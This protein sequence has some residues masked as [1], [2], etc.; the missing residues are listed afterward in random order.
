MLA[1]VPEWL[2]DFLTGAIMESRKAARSKAVGSP[3]DAYKS[4][5]PSQSEASIRFLFRN[6]VC[7]STSLLNLM[8]WS[9]F[10]WVAKNLALYPR[11]MLSIQ[12]VS[13]VVPISE[14]SALGIWIRNVLSIMSAIVDWCLLQGAE[15][16]DDAHRS[17]ISKLCRLCGNIA[18]S[19]TSRPKEKFKEDCKQY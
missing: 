8:Y 18:S 1:R 5:F 12:H 13:V 9:I 16:A 14:K 3:P 15:M 6:Q 10:L 11:L 2:K 19:N 17:K 4:K 7:F